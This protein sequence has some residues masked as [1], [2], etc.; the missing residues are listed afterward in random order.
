MQQAKGGRGG[1]IAIRRHK[2]E[3]YRTLGFDETPIKT[4][5]Y[6]HHYTITYTQ[7]CA[8]GAGSSSRLV[9]TARTE[10]ERQAS[11][12]CAQARPKQ[13]TIARTHELHNTPPPGHTGQNSARERGS[14]STSG[15]WWS[16]A[17]RIHI[18]LCYKSI[19][20]VTAD[21]ALAS[22]LIGS[23]SGSGPE[24]SGQ[25]VQAAAGQQDRR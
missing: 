8:T 13:L 25:G 4:K 1:A 3:S 21:T 22:S 15:R 12:G 20:A 18:P 17:W 10:V 2:S 23:G 6:L 14:A 24:R 9:D 5:A 11:E 16:G 7:R 19:A